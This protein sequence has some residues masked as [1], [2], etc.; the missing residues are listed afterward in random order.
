MPEY[1]YSLHP[2][3]RV[4]HIARDAQPT[5][6][7]AL[8][9]RFALA[10]RVPAERYLC[11]KC[12]RQAQGVADLAERLAARDALL[13][14]LLMRGFTKAAIGRRMGVGTR[15]V[16]TWKQAA[17]R[18]AGASTTF[19]WLYELGRAVGRAETLPSSGPASSRSRQ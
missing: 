1:V 7:A 9:R 8:S 14:G 12:Y 17:Q 4:A 16:H 18:R 11:S 15:T 3:A 6:R 13:A 10:E 5:C 19:A 2:N